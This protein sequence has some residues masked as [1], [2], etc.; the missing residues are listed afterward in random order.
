VK[1]NPIPEAGRQGDPEARRDQLNFDACELWLAALL[2]KA[3]EPVL[4]SWR[5]RGQCGASL[6]RKRS[7]GSSQMTA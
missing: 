2:E 5:S 4:K 6:A 7:S 3:S 1:E